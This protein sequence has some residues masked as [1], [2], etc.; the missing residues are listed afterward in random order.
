MRCTARVEGS[1]D[2]STVMR[3]I[4]PSPRSSLHAAVVI[5]LTPCAVTGCKR[6]S[7]F[8]SRMRQPRGGGGG[9]NGPQTAGILTKTGQIHAYIAPEPPRRGPLACGGSLSLVS[10]YCPWAAPQGPARLRRLP[11]LSHMRVV[12]CAILH[13]IHTHVARHWAARFWRPERAKARR[14]S[15]GTDV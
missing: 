14:G 12:Q 13:S 5:W 7:T 8:Q 11:K 3:G 6:G 9:Q 4:N 10:V 2:R 15:V 1:I